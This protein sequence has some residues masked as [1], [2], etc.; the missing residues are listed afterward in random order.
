MLKPPK[1][2]VIHYGKQTSH[3]I[4]QALES[5]GVL[6]ALITSIYEKKANLS[7]II[8]SLLRFFSKGNPS[9][10]IEGLDYSKVFTINELLGWLILILGRLDKT[11]FFYSRIVNYSKKKYAFSASRLIK[12]LKPDILVVYESVYLFDLLSK[13]TNLGVIKVIHHVGVPLSGM[14]NLSLQDKKLNYRYYYSWVREFKNLSSDVEACKSGDL[15]SDYHIVSSRFVGKE[16]SRVGVDE[17]KIIVSPQGVDFL[18]KRRKEL[19]GFS[20]KTPIKFLYIGRVSQ[21]KGIKYLFDAFRGIDPKDF[22]LTIV[23]EYWNDTLYREHSKGFKFLGQITKEE[24]IQQYNSHD[25]FVN[26]TLSEGMSQVNLE[27]MQMGLPIITTINSGFENI[28]VNH[29]NGFLIEPFD[30]NSLRNAILE[31]INDPN[32]INQLGEQ[33]SL[34]GLKYTIENFQD[35]FVANI[36][37]IWSNQ[38]GY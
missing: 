37:K 7:R 21:P 34:D 5:E 2:V 29:R 31:F 25:V 12:T 19:A 24:V 9:R 14:I 17:S 11:K 26:P 28:I 8:Y 16:L 20:Y 30:S 1:V 10:R 32:L 4:T 6:L 18:H 27:A 22:S 38:N 35:S 3:I 23:G 36:S 13:E 15:L 33:A